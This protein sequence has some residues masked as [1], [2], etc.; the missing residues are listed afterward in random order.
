[1]PIYTA[2]YGTMHL[3]LSTQRETTLPTTR[4]GQCEQPPKEPT[5]PGEPPRKP[6]RLL[7]DPPTP[8]LLYTLKWSPST[9]PTSPP[10]KNQGGIVNVAE[11]LRRI[12]TH[13]ALT[14]HLELWEWD[15]SVSIDRHG[16]AYVH[17]GLNFG[18]PTREADFSRRRLV[19]SK[20]RAKCKSNRQLPFGIR[21]RVHRFRSIWR[22]NWTFGGWQC[23]SSRFWFRLGPSL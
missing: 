9:P 14:F 6:P 11:T 20:M 4:N 19:N 18:L 23:V 12:Y 16:Q 21:G 8:N 7:T 2:T 13:L 1:M 10:A 15:E 5:G 22:G 3:I 17:P